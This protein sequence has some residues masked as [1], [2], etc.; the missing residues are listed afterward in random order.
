MVPSDSRKFRRKI[1]GEIGENRLPVV[2]FGD[3]AERESSV[4]F[5]IYRTH[6]HQPLSGTFLQNPQESLFEQT[7]HKNDDDRPREEFCGAQIDLREIQPLADG[8]VRHTDDFG[9]DP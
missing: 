4:I 7:A 1:P 3:G 6:S 5:F 9:S 8:T 2:G